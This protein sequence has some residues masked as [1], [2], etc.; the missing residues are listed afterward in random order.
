MEREE[1][2]CAQGGG[3]VFSTPSATSDV[4]HLFI[5]KENV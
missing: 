3:W 5:E 1:A 2:K 4:L